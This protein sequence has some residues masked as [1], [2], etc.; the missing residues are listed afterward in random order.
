M[1]ILK[2]LHYNIEGDGRK[3][4][5]IIISKRQNEESLYLYDSIVLI[6]LIYFG[7]LFLHVDK[8]VLLVL[9]FELLEA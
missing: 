9:I 4:V 1:I 8:K 7:L 3:I 5:L 6:V 2:V